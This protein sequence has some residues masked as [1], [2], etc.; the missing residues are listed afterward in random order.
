[1]TAAPEFL[2]GDIKIRRRCAWVEDPELLAREQLQR[3]ANHPEFWVR[4]YGGPG[5]HL[6]L[7]AWVDGAPEPVHIYRVIPKK[8]AMMAVEPQ[9][10]ERELERLESGCYIELRRHIAHALKRASDQ[11]AEALRKAGAK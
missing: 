6:H 9:F 8:S 3:G 10:L 1:M 11:A 2:A 7:S 5:L 4:A